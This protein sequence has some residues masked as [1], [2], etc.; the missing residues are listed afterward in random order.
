MIPPFPLYYSYSTI[1]P[2]GDLEICNQ[3]VP[4]QY[5]AHSQA[6]IMVET[7]T[8]PSVPLWSFLSQ[9][10]SPWGQR[11]GSLGTWTCLLLIQSCGAGW[12]LEGEM[13]SFSHRHIHT[14]GSPHAV[15]QS[16]LIQDPGRKE[17]F[18]QPQ[19][20]SGEISRLV[21]KE[22]LIM[23]SRYPIHAELLWHS[24][25]KE[26]QPSIAAHDE[27]RASGWL[28]AP[29]TRAFPGGDGIRG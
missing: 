19:A 16:P 21:Y 5:L 28:P 27:G 17:D 29:G 22:C 15:S 11:T 23:L 10:W 24:A 20:S 4:F 6:I 8:E 9:H 1:F 18:Q 25:L 12:H 2:I 26:W 3:F 13:S 14:L 7:A